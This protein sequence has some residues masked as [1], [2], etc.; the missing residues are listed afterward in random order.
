MTSRVQDGRPA[1]IAATHP[2]SPLEKL[3]WSIL[4]FQKSN[5]TKTPVPDKPCQPWDLFS[6][7]DAAG[8]APALAK[9]ERSCRSKPE[10]GSDT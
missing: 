5:S 1:F 10:E 4:C 9:M 2:Q 3:R 6:A 8:T 7:P